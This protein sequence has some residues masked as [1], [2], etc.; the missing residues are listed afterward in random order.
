MNNFNCIL[1]PDNNYFGISGKC[2]QQQLTAVL[3][4]NI[5]DSLYLVCVYIGDT[6]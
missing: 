3:G 2:S 1:K 4:T 5:A 6:S